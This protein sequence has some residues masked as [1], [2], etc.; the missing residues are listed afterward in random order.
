MNSSG[1]G[2][3]VLKLIRSTIQYL[4]LIY[5]GLLVLYC[6]SLL[7]NGLETIPRLAIAPFVYSIVVPILLFLAL[8][9]LYL[10]AYFV[11][12]DRLF[13]KRVVGVAV[14]IVVMALA[15]LLIAALL[16]SRLPEQY[17]VLES[18]ERIFEFQRGDV[19]FIAIALL[20]VVILAF[21][22]ARAE[23]REVKFVDDMFRQIA[24]FG[25]IGIL[26]LIVSALLAFMFIVLIGPFVPE[27]SQIVIFFLLAYYLI[28]A[29]IRIKISQR[30]KESSTREPPMESLPT[31]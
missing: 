15:I 23:W 14:A 22:S 17:E 1:V 25:F 7:C 8:P 19:V 9:L 12:K 16:G 11:Y 3:N 5:F 20:D 4:S 29:Y 27:H 31:E 30:G 24:K 21:L 26:L 2:L 6:F 28:S 10:I 13:I 18:I